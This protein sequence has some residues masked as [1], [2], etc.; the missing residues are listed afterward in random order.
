MLEPLGEISEYYAKNTITA[1][2]ARMK[3]KLDKVS[4]KFTHSGDKGNS[5]ED[6]CPGS[7]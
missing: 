2:E 1:V 4:A 7:L 6:S 5:V 3:A